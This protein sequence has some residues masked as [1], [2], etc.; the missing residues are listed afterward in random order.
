[1]NSRVCNDN[2]PKIVKRKYDWDGKYIEISL[3]ESH[4]RDPDF[5]H[6]VSEKRLEVTTNGT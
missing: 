3:C 6:F 2:N 4:L 5:G 1:M